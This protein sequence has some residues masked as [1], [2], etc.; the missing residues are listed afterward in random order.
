MWN[1]ARS[2]NRQN[3][4][5][6]RQYVQNQAKIAAAKLSRSQIALRDYKQQNGVFNLSQEASALVDQEKG[7][8]QKWRDARAQKAANLAQLGE[9]RRVSNEVPPAKIVPADIR[10]RPEVE[11]AQTGN[12]AARSRK[13]S[14]VTRIHAGQ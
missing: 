9:M 2:K 11:A 14:L 5:D 13:N 8:E 4:T 6:T 7:L 12:G 1:S 10:R 3:T